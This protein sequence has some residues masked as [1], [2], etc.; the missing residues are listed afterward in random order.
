[1]LSPS[2]AAKS[3][4]LS[5]PLRNSHYPKPSERKSCNELYALDILLKRVIALEDA[6]PFVVIEAAIVIEKLL[7][8]IV[9]SWR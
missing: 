8:K 3:V 7:G 6:V 4:T 5:S 1:M 9:M 2:D